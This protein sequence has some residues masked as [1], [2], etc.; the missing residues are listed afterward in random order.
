MKKTLLAIVLAATSSLAFAG[1]DAFT[2]TSNPEYN[3]NM[4]N[5]NAMSNVQVNNSGSS[6]SSMGNITCPTGTFTLGTAYNDTSI[7]QGSNANSGTVMLSYNHPTDLNGTVS[8]CVKAQKAQVRLMEQENDFNV[9]R[10]CIA[11]KSAN[12]TLD[13]TVFPWASKCAGVQ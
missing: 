8:R 13:P 2:N 1:G 5:S 3:G 11:A 7:K 6:Y 9:I 10:N 4:Y 12:I